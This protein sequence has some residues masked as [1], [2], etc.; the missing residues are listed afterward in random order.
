LIRVIDEVAS[1]L[2]GLLIVMGVLLFIPIL[3][4]LLYFE[5]YTIL[6][7]A[8]PGLVMLF[9]GMFLN[10]KFPLKERYS[11]EATV[12]IAPVGWLLVSAIGS[13]PFIFTIGMW[14]LDALFETMSGFTTT[15]MTLINNLEAIPRSILF[16]RSLTQWVGGVGIILLFTI[17]LRGS[18]ATWRLYSL[19]GR[20]E[21]FTP[22]IKS[23]IRDMWLIYFLLT[24]ICAV[25]LYLCGLS[26]FDSI[27][28]AMT[29]LSTGGFSTRTDSIMA[30]GNS[31]VKGVLCIFMTLGATSFT[32]FYNL[33][34]L[35]FRKIVNDAE[36]RTL[37]AIILFSA[38]LAVP[39]L[40]F[41]GTNIGSSILDGLFNVISIV[42]TTGYSTMNL[43]LWPTV[44]KVLLLILMIIGGSAGSTG[45]GMKV[46]RATVLYRIAKREVE[47]MTLPSSAVRPIKIGGKVLD[48]EY[49]M[50]VGSFFFIYIFA[51]LIQFLLLTIFIPDPFGALS[52]V[53]SA[54][55][56]VGPAFY[57]LNDLNNFV[58]IILVFGMWFGRLELFPVLA[59]LSKGI[60]KTVKELYE[61]RKKS[62]DV[63]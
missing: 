48:E 36:F 57:P 9:L 25:S 28:H 20:E 24:A 35:D 30:F 38:L 63:S 32:L 18:M 41:A 44:T 29:T 1:G 46:W 26:P 55:G 37:I 40:F 39:A 19:E 27:N 43:N 45:G 51:A 62:S 33:L 15:G 7:F 53:L 58:K 4:A 8:V 61:S 5:Y 12:V 50:K 3:P 6:A 17:I 60:P 42:T 21:K 59:L 56:N 54:Q 22:S 2:V 11:M 34:R 52:L 47:K 23:T 31:W 10:K 13:I 16:W 14:P 49:V